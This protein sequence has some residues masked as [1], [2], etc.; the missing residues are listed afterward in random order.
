MKVVQAMIILLLLAFPYSYF[1]M[2]MQYEV[3]TIL[4]YIVSLLI[5]VGVTIWA[6]RQRQFI[7]FI[8]GCVLTFVISYAYASRAHTDEW[9]TMFF[10]LDPA[11]F[12]IAVSAVFIIIASVLFYFLKAEKRSSYYSSRW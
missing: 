3:D 10:S 8:A 6:A 2:F 9:Q 4:G 12:S 1:S 5:L 7:V 11:Q